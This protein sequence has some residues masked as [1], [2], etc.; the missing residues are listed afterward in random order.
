MESGRDDFIIAIR[1]AFLKKENKQRFSL[2]FLIFFSL[3]FLILGRFNFTAVNYVEIIIKE[4]IYRTSFIVSL[5]ENILKKSYTTIDSHFKLYNQNSKNQIE[6]NNL[7]SQDLLNEF[8][9]L[10][11]R[12]LKSV[13][14]DYLIES[15]EIVAKVLID[16]KSPFLKTIVVNKGSKNNIKLGMSV[17]DKEYLVGKIVEVNYTTSRVLLLSDINSKIPVSIEPDG[18]QSILSGTGKD[19]GIIQYLK[20]DYEI[21]NFS[22]VYTSGSGDIFKAGVPIGRVENLSSINEKSVTFY[23]DFSQLNFVKIVSYEAAS[24]KLNDQVKLKAKK[25]AELKT[26]KEALEKA[27]KEAELKIEKE[28]LEKAKKEAELKTEKEAGLKAEKKTLEELNLEY[29]PKCK[30]TFFNKLYKV[31]SPEYKIC[32]STK[33]PEIQRKKL[34]E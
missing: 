3:I 6:L 22:K 5:P 10:E 23:S 31:G 11:N 18:I 20:R 13:I 16:K 34:E 24:I 7:R 29:G 9:I 25:E 8:I 12:R 21:Q 33:G 15:D 26:E 32:I 27:K 2:I 14:D 28:A 17:L 1:S 4:M 30:K 19:Y